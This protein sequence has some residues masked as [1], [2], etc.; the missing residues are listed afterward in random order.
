MNL[1]DTELL[2][3]VLVNW[4]LSEGNGGLL[5][6]VLQGLG[7]RWGAGCRKSREN[8]HPYPHVFTGTQVRSQKGGPSRCSKTT[9]IGL[10]EHRQGKHSRTGCYAQI[11]TK[12]P[13]PGMSWTV[14]PLAGHR[15][16]QPP[17]P[18]RY[19]HMEIWDG[20]LS[21]QCFIYVAVPGPKA[22]AWPA[23]GIR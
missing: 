16:M 1:L 19:K 23:Y 18:H 3:Q 6:F 4:G 17:C 10:G 21:L 12:G 13:A 5:L 7:M 8:K 9:W 11:F 20:D 22:V 15:I 2:Y 14:T